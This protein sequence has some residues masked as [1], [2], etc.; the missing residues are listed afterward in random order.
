MFEQAT[1]AG[2]TFT[3]RKA[4]APQEN[5]SLKGEDMRS[6]EMIVPVS[7][8]IHPGIV[9]LLATFGYGYVQVGKR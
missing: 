4:F 5:L 8:F 2:H 7:S 1:A 6:G 3:I 9:A